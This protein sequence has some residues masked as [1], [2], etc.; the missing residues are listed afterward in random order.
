MTPPLAPPV[1][2]AG[3]GRGYDNPSEG[4]RESEVVFCEITLKNFAGV[5]PI[6]P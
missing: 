4:Y 6:Y 5:T 1:P 2:L 3:D